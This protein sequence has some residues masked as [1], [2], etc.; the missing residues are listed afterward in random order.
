M[1]E[2][3]GIC[4]RYYQKLEKGAVNNPGLKTALQLA[5]VLDISLDSMVPSVCDCYV[6]IQVMPPPDIRPGGMSTPH[7]L[8]FGIVAIQLQG[9]T[10]AANHKG[11]VP[12]PHG[13]ASAGH[14]VHRMA[15]YIRCTWRM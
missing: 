9:G 2:G 12:R 10:A 5:N 4:L 11:F 6:R 7:R 15:S 8:W 1:A 13:C 14:A 3:C